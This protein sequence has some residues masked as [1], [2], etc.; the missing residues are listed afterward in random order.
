MVNW[1]VMK[2]DVRFWNLVEWIMILYY[3]KMIFLLNEVFGLVLEDIEW[4]KFVEFYIK[5]G[6]R[7][8]IREFLGN[9]F[10]DDYIGGIVL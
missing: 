10:I 6:R 8:Y 4:F 2:W 1:K 7:G 9:L 3:F 5:W